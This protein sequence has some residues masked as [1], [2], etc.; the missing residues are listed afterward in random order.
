MLQTKLDLI[1]VQVQAMKED[2][3]LLEKKCQ[4][5]QSGS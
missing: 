2:K 3:E 1:T 4:Y 5:L